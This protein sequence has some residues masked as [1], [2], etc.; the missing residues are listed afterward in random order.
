M[1]ISFTV[2]T[3]YREPLVG[4]INNLYGAGGYVLPL[5]FGLY[6]AFYVDNATVLMLA[7]VDYCANALLLSASDVARN[8]NNRGSDIPV[9]NY[10]GNYCPNAGDMYKYLT[11]GLPVP[12]RYI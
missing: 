2:T 10:T 7:P 12:Q 9:Y 5:I 3:T 1:G 11:E 4:W 8:F 6:S